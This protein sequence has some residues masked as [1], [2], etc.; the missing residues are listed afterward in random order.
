MTSF[1]ENL[2]AEKYRR[3]PEGKAE[4]KARKLHNERMGPTTSEGKKAV[5]KA[6]KK[7]DADRGASLRTT[8]FL[9]H[10]IKDNRKNK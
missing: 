3:S 7:A 1:R 5:R 9:P 8:G 4:K 10:E 6:K 2:D